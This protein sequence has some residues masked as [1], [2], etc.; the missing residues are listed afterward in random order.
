[1]R[2]SVLLASA[3]EAKAAAARALLAA[4]HASARH[5][6][7]REA[8]LT[9]ATLL[10]QA[11][12]RRQHARMLAARAKMEQKL[13][14]SLPSGTIVRAH[15]LVGAAHLNGVTG[16]V[17]GPPQAGKD[18]SLRVPVLLKGAGKARL[19]RLGNLLC[20]TGWQHLDP[21][22]RMRIMAA[23]AFSFEARCSLLRGQ[24]SCG[25]QGELLPMA[26]LRAVSRLFRSDFVG[27]LQ[28]LAAES[29]F[30]ALLRIARCHVTGDFGFERSEDLFLEATERL[31]ACDTSESVGA[32]AQL[33]YDHGHVALA[34]ELWGRGASRG[35]PI[36]IRNYA[37]SLEGEGEHGQRTAQRWWQTGAAQGD[38]YCR[39]QWGKAL[40]DGLAGVA[41]D[42]EKACELFQEAAEAGEPVG[43]LCTAML[44]D[45]KWQ[46]TEDPTAKARLARR[47]KSWLELA[48]SAGNANAAEIFEQQLWPSLSAEV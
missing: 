20:V 45:V 24:E 9:A 28:H 5:E 17:A 7:A 16:T 12:A 1:M 26:R 27:A 11:A 29:S 38:M 18:G 21:D 15:G 47:C 22:S 23:T 39:A 25:R 8:V 33:C 14:H 10:L 31:A 13:A 35:F 43:M 32:A 3:S 48:A 44:Y 34:V 37:A 30:P 2:L 36:C 42:R 19:V 40:W 41:R 4:Q 46:Q 6:A